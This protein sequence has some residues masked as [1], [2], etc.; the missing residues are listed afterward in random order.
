M[1]TTVLQTIAKVWNLLQIGS[2][3]AQPAVEP[4]LI[5]TLINNRGEFW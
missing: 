5:I 1:C 3:F 2:M 4:G